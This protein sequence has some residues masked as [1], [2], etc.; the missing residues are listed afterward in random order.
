MA[1]PRAF[2]MKQS[3]Y[4][5]LFLLLSSKKLALFLFFSFA[6]LLVPETFSQE[7][8]PF[9]KPVKFFLLSLIWLNLA[10]CTLHNFKN[11]RINTLFVH[12]GCLVT[13]I[14]SLAGHLGYVATVNIHEGSSSVEA[15]RWDFESDTPL[16][17]ELKIKKINR[18]YYPVMVKV[19]VLDNGRQ[20]GLFQLKTGESFNY[21]EY[22]IKVDSINL[23]AKSLQLNIYEE[24]KLITNFDTLQRPEVEEFP[25]EFKL[26]AFKD[27]VL[28]RIWVDIEIVKDEIKSNGVS[29]VNSPFIWQG[30]RFFHTAHGFDPTGAPYAGMQIVKDPGV[31]IVY[32][33]FMIIL[34]GGLLTLVQ[35]LGV[36]VS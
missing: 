3:F 20:A 16:G 26:V 36:R 17:F 2:L 14:G 18:L 21:K 25:F 19:G 31:P 15:Y 29:E 27:P 9:Q 30:I 10:A 28:K 7:P 12:I 13:I 11:L 5:S 23:A 1:L 24:N 6:L 34:L 32:L 35:H 22:T 8:L 33:G 4:K